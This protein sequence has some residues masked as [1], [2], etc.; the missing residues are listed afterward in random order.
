MNV[1]RILLLLIVFVSNSYGQD[2][3]SFSHENM[4]KYMNE[5]GI[6]YVNFSYHQAIHESGNFKSDLFY[7][8][9]N[10]F[11]MKLASKRASTAIG[12]RKGYA[13]YKTWQDSVM[14]FY[15]MQN[16]ILK[17]H[18]TKE[19]YYSYIFRN[20]AKDKKYKNILKKYIE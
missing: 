17:T 6:I 16:A 11:G 5:I 19:S 12:I 8:N 20:Y 9:N 4:K 10:L 14:D 15:L 1:F 2:T 7:N 13:K 18:K 3:I